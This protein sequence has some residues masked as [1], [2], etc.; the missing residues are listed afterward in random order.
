MLAAARYAAASKE[1]QHSPKS[2]MLSLLYN[3][4]IAHSL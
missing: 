2:S 1:K 4:A 3:N